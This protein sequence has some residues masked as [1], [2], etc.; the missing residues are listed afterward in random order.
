MGKIVLYPAF[1]IFKCGEDI[2]KFFVIII[3]KIIILASK[4]A[5]FTCVGVTRY[6]HFQTFS[7]CVC[8]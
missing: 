3:I 1:S 4:W 6:F 7:S 2:L 8:M 5:L